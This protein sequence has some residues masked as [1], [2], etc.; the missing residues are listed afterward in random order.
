MIKGIFAFLEC[1]K[2]SY[3][4]DLMNIYYGLKSCIPFFKIL[5]SE[6]VCGLAVI[7]QVSLELSERHCVLAVECKGMQY[8]HLSS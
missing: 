7:L 1:G 3:F 2:I 6:N 4:P 8:Q 5:I